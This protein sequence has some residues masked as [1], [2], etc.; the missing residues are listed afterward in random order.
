MY[1]TL[2][3]ATLPLHYHYTT[4]TLPLHYHN[5]N[6]NDNSYNSYSN[7]CNYSYN[8]S[9][10]TLHCLHYNHSSNCSYI[11]LHYATLHYTTAQHSTT[12][13]SARQHST[14]QD[15]TRQDNTT[16]HHTTTTTSTTTTTAT[17]TA[18]TTTT[19]TT[20]TLRTLQRQIRY[21]A[22]HHSTSSG[23]GW[24]YHCNHSKTRHSNH[25]RVRSAIHASQQPT[26]P[27]GFLSLKLPPPPCAV[28]LIWHYHFF[29]VPK[30]FY[31]LGALPR[32]Y[33]DWNGA[34]MTNKPKDQAFQKDLTS[35]AWPQNQTLERQESWDCPEKQSLD[36]LLDWNPK[37]FATKNINPRWIARCCKPNLRNSEPIGAWHLGAICRPGLMNLCQPSTAKEKHAMPISFWETLL[38][39][40]FQTEQPFCWK[41]RKFLCE[42][43]QHATDIMAKH[44]GKASGSP[45]EKERF[46]LDFHVVT[47]LRVQHSQVVLTNSVYIGME[48][49]YSMTN[50][51]DAPA[52]F[53]FYVFPSPARWGEGCYRFYVSWPALSSSSSSSACSSAGPQLQALDGSVPRRT[54]TAS[55]C[56][57][58]DLRCKR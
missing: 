15:N 21:T 30:R 19:T 33:W 45:R 31:C 35:L 58:P 44:R 43:H 13:R 49:Q 6:C 50:V 53:P 32:S 4:T 55:E 24:G 17:A 47:C 38:K 27:I 2:H 36:R 28:L 5:C 1:A 51:S 48:V 29:G 54:R 9:F 7:Y 42:N 12:Q 11:T 10:T 57:P 16:Q 14:A 20:T 34:V 26:L 40:P 37:L 3:Y 23:C 22:L 39:T 41:I 46:D 56:S 18:I 8:Y 52:T 25:L